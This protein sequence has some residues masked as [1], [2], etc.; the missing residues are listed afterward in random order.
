[1]P[2]PLLVQ[3]DVIEV[4]SGTSTKDVIR[5][6]NSKLFMI[7]HMWIGGEENMKFWLELLVWYIYVRYVNGFVGFH[8]SDAEEDIIFAM[9]G[10]YHVNGKYNCYFS[11]ATNVLVLNKKLN[12]TRSECIDLLCYKQRLVTSFSMVTDYLDHGY[13]KFGFVSLDIAPITRTSPTIPVAIPREYATYS[14]T[15]ASIQFPISL[16]P[17]PSSGKARN[18]VSLLTELVHIFLGPR[19]KTRKRNL[20]M[21][22][23]STK[24]LTV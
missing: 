10:Q 13:M 5:Q 20:L 21:A 18:A 3:Y 6:C 23:C 24:F 17:N 9:P 4:S 22:L 11:L 12:S 14:R 16:M 19:Q 15:S 2:L 7:R 8:F 1:M